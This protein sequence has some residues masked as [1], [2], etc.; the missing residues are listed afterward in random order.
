MAPRGKITPF[1]FRI[2][3]LPP[4]VVTNIFRYVIWSAV[5]TKHAVQWR[6]W[7]TG[8]CVYWREIA[9]K[10]PLLW[11]FIWVD[12]LPNFER[13]LTWLKRSSN[14][15]LDILIN[16]TKERPISVST[17]QNLLERLFNKISN[18]RMIAIN[19]QE[20]DPI[21]VVLDAFRVVQKKGCPMILERL[22]MHSSGSPSVQIGTSYKY[23]KPI[24]LFGGATVPS[25]KSLTLNGVN[26]DWTTP[27]LTNI[28]VLDIRRLPLDRSPTLSQFRALLGGSPALHKLRLDGV[29]PELLE[30]TTPGLKP[31]LIPSLRLLSLAN[32]SEQYAT[33]V[34]AQIF[35]PNVLKLRLRNLFGEDYSM[36]Y[37]LL[38]SNMPKI[39]IL[40]LHNIGFV[41]GPRSSIS[42]IGW[43]QSMPLLTLFRIGN[44]KPQFLEFFLYIGK[45]PAQEPS[46]CILC[47]KL[48]FLEVDVAQTDVIARW[49]HIRRQLGSPLQKIYLSADVAKQF[50]GASG[51]VGIICVLTPG[52]RPVEEEDLHREDIH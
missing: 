27:I 46:R 41:P 40:W 15:P 5:S 37:D 22:E 17:L 52:N 51:G 35:A 48:A 38:R 50:A 20:L 32:F 31:V 2:N 29:S 24:P 36:L 11:S 1:I 12:D 14:A 28:T 43:L 4:E 39:K 23:P 25:L 6:L 34:C 3:R 10:D 26:I 30:K 19:F 42:V 7:L 18:I 9:L 47:P 49:T 45:K 21:L 8:V 33:Y 16:D 44:V 13:S